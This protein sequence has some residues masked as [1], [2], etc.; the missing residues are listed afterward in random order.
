MPYPS[1]APLLRSI[2]AA[3]AL[4][5]AV[6]AVAQEASRDTSPSDSEI[7]QEPVLL[8]PF[9]V[10]A[11]QTQGYRVAAAVTGT[12]TAGLIKDTP[13]N[14]SVVSHELIEDQVGNQLVD[15][16]RSASAVA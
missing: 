3:F 1:F 2:A 5:G 10:S 7:S 11:S 16:L 6:G 8:S 4:V 9:E 13:L 14:I 12:G 15:V